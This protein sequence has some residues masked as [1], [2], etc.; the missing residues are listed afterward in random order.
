MAQRLSKARPA[1]E[2]T[3]APEADGVFEVVDERQIAEMRE[4]LSAEY[5]IGQGRLVPLDDPAK[6]N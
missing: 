3:F 5:G 6:A 4:K 2:Q 1:N